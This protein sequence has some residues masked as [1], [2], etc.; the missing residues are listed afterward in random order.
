[1]G[2]SY[3]Q[4]LPDHGQLGAIWDFHLQSCKAF[5]DFDD[6]IGQM[7]TPGQGGV[8]WEGKT[9]HT[10]LGG[11]TVLIFS[12]IYTDILNKIQNFNKKKIKIESFFNFFFYRTN[13]LKK[14][15]L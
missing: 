9:L 8:E 14:F 10:T 1:M 5:S 6:F 2:R 4:G 7:R 15:S 13:L 11:F 3:L 12:L